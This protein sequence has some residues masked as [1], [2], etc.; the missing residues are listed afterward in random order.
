MPPA[1]FALGINF[2]KVSHLYI[3]TWASLD[4]DSPV[5]TSN[6]VEMTGVHHH[7]LFLLV[8]MGVSQTFCSGWP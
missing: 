2:K 8:E 3:Y 7:V 4:Y 5:S 6:I 1:L